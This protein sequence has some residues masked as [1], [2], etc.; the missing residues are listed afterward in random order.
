M[1]T[2]YENFLLWMKSKKGQKAENSYEAQAKEAL[3]SKYL[4]DAIGGKTLNSEEAKEGMI[5]L[6]SI[7]GI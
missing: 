6:E 7:R 2:P 5:E 1:S 4:L 3:Q